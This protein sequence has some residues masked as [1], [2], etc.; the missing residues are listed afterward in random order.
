MSSLNFLLEDEDQLKAGVALVDFSQLALATVTHTYLN[1][2]EPLELDFIRHLI[3][4][5][6]RYNVTKFKNEGYD[7]F[8]FCIDNAKPM[9]WRREFA[10]YYKKLRK[11]SRDGSSFDWDQYYKIIEVIIQELQMYMPYIFINVSK[12]EADDCIGVL[13]KKL[14]LQGIPVIIVSSDGDY[15]QLHKFPNVKQW[16]PMHKKFVTSKSGSPKLDLFTKII[17]GDK[18]DTVSGIKVRSSFYLD[19]LEGER[20]PQSSAA[21]VESLVDAENDEAIQKLLTEDQWKRFVENRILIDFDYIRE[22]IQEAILKAYDEAK[23]APR[24]KIYSYFVKKG[25]KK[26]LTETNSF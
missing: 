15:S 14:T 20:T 7:K 3:L 18:K 11:I 26:L 5:T 12:A 24:G 17:K 2:D 1:R 25:L 22:D 4:D 8:I 23:P 21:F 13:V 6:I 9:Y 10:W 19:K 16:S